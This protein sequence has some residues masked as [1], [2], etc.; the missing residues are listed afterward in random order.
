MNTG[1]ESPIPPEAAYE[2][3]E[4]MKL[5]EDPFV[6]F[7][8]PRTTRYHVICETCHNVDFLRAGEDTSPCRRCGEPKDMR[9]IRKVVT[10]LTPWGSMVVPEEAAQ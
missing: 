7:E 10:K 1:G 6:P 9:I 8:F 4:S 5:S 2:Y 3:P